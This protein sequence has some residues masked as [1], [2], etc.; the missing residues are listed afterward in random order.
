MA[1]DYPDAP[2]VGQAFQGFVWDGEKWLVAPSVTAPVPYINSGYLSW[3]GT[4]Q[5]AF[6][7]YGGNAIRIGGA[8]LTIPAAGIAGLG[9]PTSVYVNGVAGQALAVGT[10]Y[11]I[12]AFNN[13]GVITADFSTTVGHSTSATA[14][15]VGTEIKT[16]D[17]SRTLIGM[18][19]T[20]TGPI[21]SAGF[22]TLSWFNRRNKSNYV[23]TS[24]GLVQATQGFC[25]W[26]DES[27]ALSYEGYLAANAIS[28]N[29]SRHYLDSVGNGSTLASTTGGANYTCPHTGRMDILLAEGYH[30][31]GAITTLSATPSVVAFSSSVMVRG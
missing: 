17:D 7:P 6:K 16:G 24:G 18:V 14:G 21:Y 22:T 8:I 11:Y 20:G 19:L 13:A 10:L 25:T 31:Y 12:Y 27:V 2:S 3:A 4:T 15:N 26:G 23:S 1:Y 30:T 5:L 29:S 28:N 9:A